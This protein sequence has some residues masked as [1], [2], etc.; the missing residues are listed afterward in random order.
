VLF[1]QFRLVCSIE[2]V[3]RF[4]LLPSSSQVAMGN[5]ASIPFGDGDTRW[6][7]AHFLDVAEFSSAFGIAYDW[8]FDGFSDEQKT[9]IRNALVTNGLQYCKGAL[10]GASSASTFSWWTAVDGNWNVR[11]SIPTY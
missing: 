10:E 6:N 11:F 1:F 2:F 3:G 7:P 8:F 5:D 4:F 9:T